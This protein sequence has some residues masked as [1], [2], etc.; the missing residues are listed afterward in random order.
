VTERREGGKEGGRECALYLRKNRPICNTQQCLWAHRP[1]RI[2]CFHRHCICIQTT[3]SRWGNPN[4]TFRPSLLGLLTEYTSDSPANPSC[5]VTPPKVTTLTLRYFRSSIHDYLHSRHVIG[6]G[7]VEVKIKYYERVVHEVQPPAR[8]HQVCQFTCGPLT[9]AALCQPQGVPPEDTCRGEVA[10]LSEDGNVTL[11]REVIALSE[12]SSHLRESI[13][14]VNAHATGTTLQR[15]L[16][17]DAQRC[18]CSCDTPYC[19]PTTRPTTNPARQRVTHP[20][21]PADVTPASDGI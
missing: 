15:R 11:A 19:K 5:C 3:G 8:K 20:I 6:N 16:T 21:V 9:E 18:Q 13:M 10:Y 2:Q 17:K 14:Y 7:G 4:L 12:R 1:P